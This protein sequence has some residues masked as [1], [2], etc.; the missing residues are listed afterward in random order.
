MITF[1][2]EERQALQILV[3]HAADNCG[4]GE[5]VM[6]AVLYTGAFR[7]FSKYLSQ[8]NTDPEVVSRFVRK[9]EGEKMGDAIDIK[10]FSLGT[11]PEQT[12]DKNSTHSSYKQK[13]YKGY[14]EEQ[15]RSMDVRQNLL[16]ATLY[17]E[18]GDGSV[19]VGLN[20]N[21]LHIKFE[22]FVS[23]VNYCHFVFYFKG[24]AL[25]CHNLNADDV[26]IALDWC[27]PDILG[28]IV[29]FCKSFSPRSS[30][31]EQRSSKP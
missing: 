19:V 28:K 3:K 29:K 26:S 2:E 4:A 14:T 23:G 10:D 7:C 12:S 17:D 22:Q 8:D 5:D 21:T 30:K 20:P 6:G 27:D 1:T 24:N 11:R 31:E 9:I 18:I 25:D 15:K 13:I 16:I